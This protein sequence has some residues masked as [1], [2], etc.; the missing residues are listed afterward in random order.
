MLKGVVSSIEGNL[1][2]VVLPERDNSVSPP[3]KVAVHVGE[4]A[5]GDNVA[6]ATFSG[7]LTDG[8]IIAKY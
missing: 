6:V 4:L 3:L 5:V 2:R 8:L 7:G 1:V